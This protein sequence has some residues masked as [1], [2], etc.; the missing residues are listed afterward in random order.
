[1]SDSRAYEYKS[2]TVS[3]A[4]HSNDT[5]DAYDSESKSNRSHYYGDKYVQDDRSAPQ[6]TVASRR[7]KTSVYKTDDVDELDESLSHDDHSSSNLLNSYPDLTIPRVHEP[8]PPSLYDHSPD[9][10]IPEEE[11]EDL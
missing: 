3:T 4:Y 10:V 5:S 1:M 6:T 2:N 11:Y 7:S 8:I 9:N